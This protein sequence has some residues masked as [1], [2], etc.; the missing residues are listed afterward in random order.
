MNVF[1][2]LVPREL[3]D[4]VA[5]SAAF[6]QQGRA[7]LAARQAQ[8]SASGKGIAAWLKVADCSV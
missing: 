5:I 7:F 3:R 4:M 6:V 1:S 2:W 8:Y